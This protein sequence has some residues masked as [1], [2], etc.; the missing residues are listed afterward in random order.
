MTTGKAIALTRRTFVG[1]LDMLFTRINYSNL[2][3]MNY[4]LFEAYS[5]NN[6]L[7][8]CFVYVCSCMWY[9]VHQQW[10]QL[11]FG[12]IVVTKRILYNLPSVR[13]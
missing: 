1:K 6:H 4:L 11:K 5:S 9:C 10:T 13:L 8:E 2:V 12:A 7:L 3:Q